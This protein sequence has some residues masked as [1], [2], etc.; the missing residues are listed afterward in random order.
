M[1]LPMNDDDFYC[2]FLTMFVVS[3]SGHHLER[4]SPHCGGRSR[5]VHSS[6][7]YLHLVRLCGVHARCSLLER[8]RDY[9]CA[10]MHIRWLM[11]GRQ[12]CPPYTGEMRD[13]VAQ[14]L[15]EDSDWDR[16]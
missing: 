2:V 11:Y 4:K 12:T 16:R 13:H 10:G 6:P 7:L 1:I 3:F 5:Y 14:L 8:R 15:A 9:Y